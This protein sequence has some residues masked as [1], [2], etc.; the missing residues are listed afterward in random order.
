[1]HP[2][3]FGEGI[4]RNPTTCKTQNKVVAN[5]WIIQKLLCKNKFPMS[6]PSWNQGDHPA[7]WWTRQRSQILHLASNST[8]TSRSSK[9]Y[10][11]WN[12]RERSWGWVLRVRILQDWICP[13]RGRQQPDSHHAQLHGIH[14]PRHPWRYR[15]VMRIVWWGGHSTLAA[16][17]VGM[18]EVPWSGVATKGTNRV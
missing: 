6:L 2:D 10:F 14:V 4:S 13:L 5:K 17:M 9:W 16:A 8:Q 18:M 15:F 11:T 3:A 12:P 1:M 7:P